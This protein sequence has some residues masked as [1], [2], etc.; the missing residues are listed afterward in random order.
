MKRILI[1]LALAIGFYFLYKEIRWRWSN[2]S[3][4]KVEVSNDLNLNQVKIIATHR[5][6]DEV[7]FEKGRQVSA[8]VSV[9]EEQP[10]FWEIVYADSLH[11]QVESGAFRDYREDFDYKFRFFTGHDTLYCHYSR[12]A[13]NVVVHLKR[14]IKHH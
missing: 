13:E 11:A 5:M 14:R 3:T 6:G 1:S 9:F 8:H 12:D 4:I 10:P 7:I 2:D